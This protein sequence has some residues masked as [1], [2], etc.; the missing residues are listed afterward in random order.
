[1]KKVLLISAAFLF[2]AT[3]AFSQQQEPEV[4]TE[5][6]TGITTPEVN[7]PGQAEHGQN[8][9]N[10]ARET[11]S[12]EII[13]AEARKKGEAKRAEKLEKRDQRKSE[14]TNRVG[15]PERPERPERPDR[16]E[17]LQGRP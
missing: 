7:T 3:M 10:L 17:R 16:P 6:Q 14:R 4:V 15:R 12:G 1:M 9:S 8:I 2:T 11:Q 13:S 5:P